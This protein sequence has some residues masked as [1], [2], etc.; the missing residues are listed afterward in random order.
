[1]IPKFAFEYMDGGCNEDVN[2]A[3][4]TKEIR[5]IELIP[6]YLKEHKG[7]SMKTELFGHE[8]DAPFG[9][10]PIGLQGLIWPNA[11]KILAQ[12]AKDHNVPFCLSTI[13]TESI[14]EIG[15]IQ[16]GKAWFLLYHPTEDEL[17]D[18]LIKR[19]KDAGFSTLIVL[20]DVPTFGFRPR[21]IRNGL[22]MPPRWTLPNI[23]EIVKH[24]TWA[25]ST[26]Y[27]G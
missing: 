27:H 18:K 22:S 16:D 25:L 24:P 15:K 10:A 6:R 7:S 1:M 4:N 8:W 23:W 2:L 14:E 5:D 3:K 9:I 13:S 11:P 21:D 20:C 12:A 19:A 26:L 17:R